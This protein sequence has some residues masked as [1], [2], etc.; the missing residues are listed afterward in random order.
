MVYLKGQKYECKY[1]R[2][3]HTKKHGNVFFFADRKCAEIRQRIISKHGDK[4]PWW[5]IIVTNR[6]GDVTNV[7]SFHWSR[8][9][10]CQKWFLSILF[11][12][13]YYYLPSH[14]RQI[15]LNNYSTWVTDVNPTS[16][17]DRQEEAWKY[18]MKSN[19]EV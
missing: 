9:Q 19:V 5:T 18:L 10:C 16:F 12:F 17:F 11:H 8:N 4:P 13:F 6:E 15:K 2:K 14:H 7:C 3:R 1:I